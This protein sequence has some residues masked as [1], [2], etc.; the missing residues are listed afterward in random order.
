M[1]GIYRSAYPD[2][3]SDPQN[4]FVDAARRSVFR[5]VYSAGS[6]K[7]FLTS[8]TNA[9][10]KFATGSIT[11]KTL[12]G[13]DYRDFKQ[14][15][16]SAYGY[17]TTPFDLYAPVYNPVTPPIRRRT[18]TCASAWLGSTLRTRCTTRELAGGR[19]RSSRYVHDRT[20][21][22]TEHRHPCHDRSRRIDVRIAFRHDAVCHLRHILQSGLHG[23]ILH[24]RRLR[25]AAWRDGRGWIQVQCDTR[26]H[27]QRRHF[28]H[29]RKEPPGGRPQWLADLQP[30]RGSTYSRRRTRTA[31]PCHARPRSDRRLLLPRCTHRKRRQRRQGVSRPSR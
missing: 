12:F 15:Q 30:D 26:C 6:A 28:R 14:Q 11:H 13:V 7:D 8:D 23:G 21:G 3:Y 9:E 24:D 22:L 2:V 17:D 29:G 20:A 16:S 4:P 27:R 1:D 19:R 18:R 10:L 31:R 25:T 5:Y